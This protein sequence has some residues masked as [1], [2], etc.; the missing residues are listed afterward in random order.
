MCGCVPAC[1]QRWRVL[2]TESPTLCSDGQSLVI[3]A[4][5]QQ[6][7][8][9]SVR[10]PSARSASELAGFSLT[11]AALLPVALAVFGALWEPPP[12]VLLGRCPVQ[13][14]VHFVRSSAVPDSGYWQM[15]ELTVCPFLACL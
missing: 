6:L 9:T 2:A 11:R 14:G 5:V 3:P 8:C 7:V 13:G 10:T 15:S 1:G 12:P 4:G